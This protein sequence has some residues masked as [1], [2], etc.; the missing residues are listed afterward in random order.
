MCTRTHAL[1]K[2]QPSRGQTVLPGRIEP[3]HRSPAFALDDDD[4]D[5]SSWWSLASVGFSQKS[6]LSMY[7]SVLA[8]KPLC[9]ATWC[10]RDRRNQITSVT[11]LARARSKSKFFLTQRPMGSLIKKKKVHTNPITSGMRGRPS[12]FPAK[13][14]KTA[15]LLH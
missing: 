4:D 12:C 2:E 14:R 15:Q 11:G 5:D 10:H 8:R 13:K 6:W 7:C 3:E 9:I 1:M